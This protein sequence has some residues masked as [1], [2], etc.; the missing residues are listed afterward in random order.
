MALVAD[1]VKANKV[2]DVMSTPEGI[3]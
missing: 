1:G 2:Y 3:D